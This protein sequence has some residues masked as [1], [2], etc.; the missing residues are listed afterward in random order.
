MQAKDGIEDYL[1]STLV[2]K[3]VE[4]KIPASCK[5]NACILGVDEAGRGPVLGPMCF[6]L[7]FFPQN[8]EDVLNRM[9]FA[10]SKTLTDVKR[11][12]L[13][14]AIQTQGG[15]FQEMGYLVKIIAPNMI[16]NSMLRR[17]KYDLNSL[18]HDTTIDL[19]RTVVSKGLNISHVYIDTVG[20]EIK[21]KDKLRSFFPKINFTVAQKADSK[22]PIVSAASVCA[23]VVRDRIV[24]NW[25]YVE[26]D[27]LYLQGLKMGSGYPADPD[28]K[29]F[30][31][32]SIDP[33]FGFTT[34]AR[35]S[36]STIPRALE[37]SGCNCD[38]N[39]PKDDKPSHK[40]LSKQASFMQ[41]FLVKNKST[42]SRGGRLPAPCS[43]Q[44]GSTSLANNKNPATGIC[45][46]ADKFLQERQLSRMQYLCIG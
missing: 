5:K 21:Y 29:K 20:T 1:N 38:W 44:V 22:Y 4:S 17:H 14:E 2:N 35:F 24:Q 32:D 16:S 9:T 37:K 27:S 40:Q 15:G 42:A 36:W 18:S 3:L 11:E 26:C 33:V 23:K 12:S 8:L 6:G 34:L 31:E 28:T 19:I 7:A 46:T 25:R 43:P 41:N 10:D 30:L 13:F 45:S 39:E